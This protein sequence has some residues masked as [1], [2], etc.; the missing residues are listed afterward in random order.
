E[1]VDEGLLVDPEYGGVA[2]GRRR[3]EARLVIEERPSTERFVRLRRRHVH[4]I[5][6]QAHGAGYHDVHRVAGVVLLVDALAGLESLLLLDH[7][8]DGRG[9]SS[10]EH[11]VEELDGLRP[12]GAHG[13]RYAMV[14]VHHL[15]L[16]VEE[17]ENAKRALGQPGALL[18]ERTREQR[19]LDRRARV[20]HV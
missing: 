10:L 12:D 7:A 2:R 6:V 5:L 9:D 17:R 20:E 4:L 15:L 18:A 8:E 14:R 11:V 16:S 19:A 1:E 13:A 3:H